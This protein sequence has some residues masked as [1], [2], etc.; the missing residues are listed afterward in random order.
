MKGPTRSEELI[1]FKQREILPRC[2]ISAVVVVVASA[3]L[4][5]AGKIAL[6]LL[7]D[8][9]RKLF[10]QLEG[11]L[12]LIVRW[13][14]RRVLGVED[15]CGRDDDGAAGRFETWD[16]GLEEWICSKNYQPDS[17]HCLILELCK[18][19]GKGEG[20]ICWRTILSQFCCSAFGG[21][22]EWSESDT[23]HAWC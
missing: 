21:W 6:Q 18:G 13:S 19:E 14:G 15:A 2:P 10:A 8:R 1:L 4:Y 17:P 22:R 20:M 12:K 5:V 23:N 16:D 3:P 11:W 7:V 9:V